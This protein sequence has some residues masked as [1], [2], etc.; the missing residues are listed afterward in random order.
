MACYTTAFGVRKLDVWILKLRPD[1][2][3]EWQKTYGGDNIDLAYSIRQTKDGGYIV[4]GWTESFGAGW[5]DV[6]VL[7][8]KPDGTVEW[9][10]TYGGGGSD[11]A[12]CIQETRDGGYIVAGCTTSFVEYGA[13]WVLKLRD[14]GAVEWQ[15]TYEGGDIDWANSVQQTTDGGY[16]VAGWTYSS[17]SGQCD[18]LV[19]RLRPDGA[20][21][22][23]K[24]YGG[25]GSDRA[26]HI[27]QTSDGGYIVAGETQSF[28]AG[29]GDVWALKLRTDG[30]VEWQKTYG[31]VSWDLAHSVQQAS[32]G[33]YMVAGETLSFG[34]G[35]GDVWVLK[36]GPDGAVEWQKTYGGIKWDG[37]RFV[38]QT[39]DGGYIVTGATSSFG[40]K[41]GL[42]VL[43]LVP[44]GSMG[45]Y[46]SFMGDTS[47]SGKDSAAT[48]KVS[49][50]KAED[51]NANPRD[52]S[53]MVR[54]TN[55]PAN[56]LYQILEI[57]R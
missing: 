54:D 11:E 44:D 43:K 18:L 48:V 42:L 51:S 35:G 46:C 3:V 25:N 27:Q 16:I 30:T 40:S 9:Q 52:S 24:T 13:I 6:W 47:I 1:G 31:G 41:G 15:K 5:Q 34:V 33:G 12:Y 50:V 38:Q 21:E 7:K 39:N 4:A 22:W 45:S 29:G 19:L 14:D 56:F 2:T 8:L 37:A 57:K 28:G 17:S 32:D 36:L 53:A 23:Q 49:S 55:V 10:E 26:N 20:V